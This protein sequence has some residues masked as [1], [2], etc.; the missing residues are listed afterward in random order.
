M[1]KIKLTVEQH[2]DGALSLWIQDE[3]LGKE[4]LHRGGYALAENRDHASFYRAVA[5]G[6]AEYAAGGDQVTYIDHNG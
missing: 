3:A 4:G 1:R 5:R 6:I 2:P